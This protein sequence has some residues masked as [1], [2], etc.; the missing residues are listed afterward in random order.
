MRAEAERYDLAA[1]KSYTHVGRQWALD[2][3][4]GEAFLGLVE[5]IGPPIVCVHKGLGGDPTDV[6]PG[7]G[8]PPEHLVRRVPLGIRDQRAGGAA[9]AR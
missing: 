4:L 9:D 6:G 1:W 2:D 3:D 5:E 8:R 7:G